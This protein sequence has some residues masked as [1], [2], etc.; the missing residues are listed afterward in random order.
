MR[1]GIDKIMRAFIFGAGASLHVGYPLAP[2]LGRSLVDWAAKNLPAPHL[3]WID[4]D[5][6]STI[7]NEQELDDFEGIITELENPII[8]SPV[9]ALPKWKRGSMLEGFRNALCYFFDSIRANDAPLYRQFAKEVIQPGDTVIT[10]NYD[11]SLERELRR[12]GKWGIRDGY[13][14]DL[15]VDSL[16]PSAIKLLKLHGSTNWIDLL[17]G[18]ARGGTFG[19][20]TDSLSLRPVI[21][22]QEFEFL[23]FPEI[24]IR[25]SMAGP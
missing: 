24:K 2:P 18:G 3:Y 22:P 5:E 15:G 9:S 4:R 13:G 11:V 17:F 10:F 12:A 25:N 23:E 16:L 19:Y 7:F 6:L 1:S 14:F 8:G 20:C 21:L